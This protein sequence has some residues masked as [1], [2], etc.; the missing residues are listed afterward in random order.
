MCR[1]SPSS[2]GSD[3]SEARAQAAG[4]RLVLPIVPRAMPLNEAL[5]GAPAFL[6]A[7]AQRLGEMLK[8]GEL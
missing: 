6:E 8:S 4:F 2:A 5:A 3:L 1:R 7:G